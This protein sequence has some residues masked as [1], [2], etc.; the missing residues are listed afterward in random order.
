LE[1]LQRC[2]PDEREEEEEEEGRETR[3]EMKEE[4]RMRQVNKEKR[5]MNT[6]VL[7]SDPL[8]ANNSS[9]LVFGNSYA[10]ESNDVP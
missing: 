3:R 1:R 4:T 9:C 10:K 7:V 8:G 5:V 6:R 2:Q